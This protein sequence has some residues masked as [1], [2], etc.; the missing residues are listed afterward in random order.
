MI[1]KAQLHFT[2]IR[3]IRILRD[4]I[5]IRENLLDLFNEISKISVLYEQHF[6]FR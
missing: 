5:R 4:R 6:R 1:S 2:F 3:L